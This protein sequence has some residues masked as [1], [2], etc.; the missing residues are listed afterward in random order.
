MSVALHLSSSRSLTRM[1][2]KRA[3]TPAE[4][5][6][7]D[8]QKRLIRDSY[9]K[10]E[11]A[12]DLVAQVFFRKLF[13]LD[14]SLRAKFSGPIE[15]QVRK[16]EAAMKLT[17]ITLSQDDELKPTLKLLGVRHRQLGIRTRHY[18]MMAKA[19]IWTLDQSLEKSFTRETRAAWTALLD[20]ITRTLA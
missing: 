15:V 9:R 19:L 18:R 14:S 1:R 3:A 20:K 4:A 6:L 12:I 8:E 5:P 17:M 13:A 10:I 11:P 16:F 7:T 2:L